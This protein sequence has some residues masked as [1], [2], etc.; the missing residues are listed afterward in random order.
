MTQGLFRQESLDAHATKPLGALRLATP[1]SHQIWAAV[2]LFVAGAIIAWLCLG[3]YTRREHVSGSLV[4]Q[5]GLI[6]VTGRSADT[7]MR[8]AV[9]EGSVVHQGGVLFTVSGERSS[10]TMGDTAREITQQLKSEQVRLQAD[11]SNAQHLA[12]EQADDLRMQLRMLQNQIQ[13]LDGQ[14]GIETKES[15]DLASLLGRFESLQDKGY[16]SPL[17]VQQQRTQKMEADQQVKALTRQRFESEQQMQGVS[18]QLTQLPLTTASKLND[19]HRQVA[20]NDQAMAQNEADRE[21][22]IYAPATGIV[23]TILVKSGESLAVGQPML[24]IVPDNSPLLGQLLV[25]SSAIGFVHVGTPVVLHYKAFPFEKFGAP[26]GEVI[27]VS[28]SA[29]TPAQVTTYLGEQP[30]QEALY[31]VEVELPSQTVNA[32]GRLEM[33]KPGMA[34][35]ADVLLDKR[36][37]IEWILEPLFGMAH[38]DGTGA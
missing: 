2:S 22:V 38:R 32:Y 21:S 7:V 17:D 30:P 11:L 4:P 23:S 37:M 18:D 29:L 16:V 27:S 28:R 5:A 26:R 25:P 35:D 13:Q 3:H 10:A 8:I 36:R 6:T 12:D 34:L 1:V 19:L 15:Q 31:K 9:T 24:F 33:L 20:Q 14:I